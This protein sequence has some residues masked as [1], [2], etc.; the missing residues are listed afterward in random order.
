MTK[1]LA[2]DHWVRCTASVEHLIS[3]SFK[4]QRRHLYITNTRPTHS[5]CN[6]SV[7]CACCGGL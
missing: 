2:T 4:Y 6:D 5:T 7:D 3:N 1:S